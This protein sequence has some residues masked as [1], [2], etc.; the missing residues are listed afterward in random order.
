MAVCLQPWS[1][2]F[3]LQQT[4]ACRGVKCGCITSRCSTS[5]S[6][7]RSL[8]HHFAFCLHFAMLYPGPMSILLY[9]FT[10]SSKFCTWCVQA[11]CLLQVMCVTLSHYKSAIQGLPTTPK[12]PAVCCRYE[13]RYA[14]R[15]GGRSDGCATFWCDPF[16]I[17][18]VAKADMCCYQPMSCVL[19]ASSAAQLACML[20]KLALKR[21]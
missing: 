16:P 18:P 5:H 14:Q 15:S 17:I 9:T 10:R 13:G 6:L 12:L 3:I 1:L 20:L 4:V 21:L 2:W 19:E 11:E 7:C 8:C